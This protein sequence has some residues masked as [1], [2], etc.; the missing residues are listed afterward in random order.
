M[1][2]HFT[3]CELME[4]ASECLIGLDC[5]HSKGISHQVRV[6]VKVDN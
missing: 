5:L 1:G 4:I 2:V 3:E 6:Y